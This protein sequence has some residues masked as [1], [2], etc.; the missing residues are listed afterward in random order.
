MINPNSHDRNFTQ[1]MIAVFYPDELSSKQEDLCTG[2][3]S[4]QGQI[5]KGTYLREKPVLA[6][7][8][9]GSEWVFH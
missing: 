4:R 5:K 6:G 2:E 3:V 8:T 1:E 9:V 7:K